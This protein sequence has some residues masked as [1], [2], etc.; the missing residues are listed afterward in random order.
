MAKPFCGQ[1]FSQ[2]DNSAGRILRKLKKPKDHMKTTNDPPKYLACLDL[3]TEKNLNH[4]FWAS[5]IF[6]DSLAVMLT[7]LYHGNLVSKLII[8]NY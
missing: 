2:E 1:R 5:V 6:S 7:I 3:E 8:W 4:K